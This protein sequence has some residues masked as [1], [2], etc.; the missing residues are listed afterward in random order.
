MEGTDSVVGSYGLASKVPIPLPVFP[1][2]GAVT[3]FVTLLLAMPVLFFVAYLNGCKIGFSVIFIPVYYS[4]LLL[5]VYSLS[6]LCAVVYVYFRDL[7]H[8]LTILV[9][10]WFYATPVIYAGSMIPEKYKWVVLLNPVGTLF[11]EMQN[12]LIFGTWPSVR[13]FAISAVWSIGSVYI[14][15]YL[16]KHYFVEVL[17]RV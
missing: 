17:E 9:Q 4:L 3:N 15:A 2:V 6:Y 7:K 8:I 16:H 5:F 1:L 14:V 12:I 11:M 10:I 13:N